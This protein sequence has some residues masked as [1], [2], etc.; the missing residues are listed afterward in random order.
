MLRVVIQKVSITKPKDLEGLVCKTRII[1]LFY[2]DFVLTY[3]RL[4]A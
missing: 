1:P 2:N 4:K 3:L